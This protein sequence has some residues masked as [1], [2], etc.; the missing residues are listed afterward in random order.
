MHYLFPNKFL[1]HGS[2]E[3]LTGSGIVR[4]SRPLVGPVD[5]KRAAM[6]GVRAFSASLLMV[7][8]VTAAAG[9]GAVNGTAKQGLPLNPETRMTTVSRERF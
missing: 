4:E 2:Y 3:T 6:E 8:S 1:G 9:R 7:L 5:G